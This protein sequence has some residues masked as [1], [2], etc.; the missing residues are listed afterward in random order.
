MQDICKVWNLFAKVPGADVCFS[1]CNGEWCRSTTSPF[2]GLQRSWMLGY[3]CR[4]FQEKLLPFAQQ[5]INVV[6]NAIF[7]K[8]FS[9]HILGASNSPVGPLVS[10]ICH[11]TLRGKWE[12]EE[13][14]WNQCLR[15]KVGWKRSLDKLIKTYPD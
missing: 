15:M 12:I 8:S 2:F 6:I 5:V 13:L 14:F 4:K 7:W 10:A 3:F 1:C 9:F 11:S